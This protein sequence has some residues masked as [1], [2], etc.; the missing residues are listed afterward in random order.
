MILGGVTYWKHRGPHESD[1]QTG[2]RTQQKEQNDSDVLYTST[3]LKTKHNKSEEK[4]D[5][6]YS[7]VV[8]SN[9]VRAAHTPVTS[10]DTAVY[11]SIKTN[12]HT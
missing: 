8:H 10:G 6:T 9:T 4:D 7:T 2:Q 11:A 12:T 3:N 5:V 1:G